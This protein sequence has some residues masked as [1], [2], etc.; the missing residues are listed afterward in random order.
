MPVFAKFVK[1]S[2]L[3][4]K[5]EKV[6]MENEYEI[7]VLDIDAMKIEKKLLEMG[8][9]KE[10][11]F[12]Q[13]RNLYN[14][15]EEYR[16]RFIR[17]RT[18]GTK[19]TLT[20]KDKSAK[21]EIGSVKELEVE[22][23]DFEKTDEILENMIKT[24]LEVKP[25]YQIEDMFDFDKIKDKIGF[26]L[27]NYN[28]NRENLQ[29]NAWKAVQ[30]LAKVYDVFLM[31]D[32][33]MY[34]ASIPNELLRRWDIDIEE[35]DKIATSNMERMMPPILIDMMD[36][37]QNG[38]ILNPPNL[39]KE[40][41]LHNKN[42]LY[43]LSNV[44]NCSGA[45]VILYPG[46]LEKISEMAESDLYIIPSSVDEVLIFPQNNFFSA[47]ELGKIVREANRMMPKE[48]ILSDRVYEFTYAESKIHELV[49][50]RPPRRK[51]KVREC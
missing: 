45:A 12:F 27:L 2:D 51:E 50:S 47:R 25:V 49:D 14:F 38:K 17:L 28:L 33:G 23:S 7:T 35:L 3:Y 48:S 4:Y 20:I 46:V 32:D 31:R 42:K 34:T 44:K 11:D 30:D 40:E 9:V 26:K 41:K 21:K 5:G 39:L 1:D 19:T 8:A 13:K 36:A 10:G 15:H 22:V 6:R 16:G 18:N 43:V 37:I 29:D 24:M